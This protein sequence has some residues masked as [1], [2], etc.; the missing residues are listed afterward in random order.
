MLQLAVFSVLLGAVA[1]FFGALNSAKASPAKAL[2]K[3]L[4]DVLSTGGASKSGRGKGLDI[5]DPDANKFILNAIDSLE[6]QGLVQN[7]K[8]DPACMID[9][10]WKLLYTSSPGT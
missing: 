4:I 5:S 7:K 2:E 9:G 8:I 1:G 10:V 3:Q 6:A